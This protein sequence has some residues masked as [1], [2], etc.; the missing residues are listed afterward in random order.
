LLSDVGFTM[1]LQL[2][3]VMLSFENTAAF[4][5]T[6]TNEAG[7]SELW[8]IIFN[9]SEITIYRH[10]TSLLVGGDNSCRDHDWG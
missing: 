7:S 10:I 5:V 1:K 2:S 4:I 6:A 3:L 9:T 8:F